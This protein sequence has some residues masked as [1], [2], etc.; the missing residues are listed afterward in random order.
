MPRVNKGNEVNWSSLPAIVLW[1]IKDKL[2]I[3][4]SMCVEAVCRDWWFASLNY[5]KKQVV[6]DGMPWIMQ[7]NDE[8]NSSSHMFIS[9]TRKKRFTIDLPELRNSQVLF[10]KQGWILMRKK[11]F[12][13]SDGRLPDS[14]FLIN[15]FTRAKI[16]MPDV[17]EIWEYYGC[18]STKAGDPEQVVLLGA[19]RSCETM[20]RTNHI[21]D[22]V[23]NEHFSI[24]HPVVFEGCRGLISSKEHIYYINLWGKMIIYNMVNRCCRE[25]PGTRNEMGVNY[26][27]EHEG[28]IIKLFASDYGDKAPFSISTFSDNQTKWKRLSNNEMNNISF[29]LS[30][31]H[32]CF[33]ARDRGLNAYVLQPDHGG[34]PH[35]RI[36]L[37]YNVLYYD[38]ADGNSQVLQLP[39]KISATAKWVDIG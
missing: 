36:F 11:N 18:F 2:D 8:E 16:E 13:E 22:A 1:M 14:L 37:G 30:R 31:L 9:V 6:G 12:C 35:P 24:D 23:W 29:Y 10:S 19:G 7:Q 33:C 32:N 25:V 5:P 17:A 4:D 26:I 28:N 39:Y 3:F 15:P 20:L 27:L 34:L 38:V 21:G